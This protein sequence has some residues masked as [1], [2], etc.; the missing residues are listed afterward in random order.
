MMFHIHNV[1][2]EWTDFAISLSLERVIGEMGKDV[3]KLN[4]SDIKELKKV[5]SLSEYKLKKYL[6][7]HYYEKDVI[8]I[9]LES[10]KKEKPDKG[11]D[12][13]ILSEM[14]KPLVQME[15]LMPN[16]IKKYP[17]KKIIRS[18]IQKKAN[19][20]IETNKEFRLFS[21]ALTAVKKKEI[22]AEVLEK[23][24]EEF[25]TKPQVTPQDVYSSTSEVLYQV[26]GIIKHSD[27]LFKDI[28]N[29]NMRQISKVELSQL[30]KNLNKLIKIVQEKI[31]K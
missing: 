17:V 2:E 18:C 24:I 7:F 8:N 29:L 22:R 19:N 15:K 31:L 13:D 14:H 6:R 5:T 23:N 25:I 3:H 12:S 1:R 11:V 21:K 10:E 9:F 30:K 28:N 4:P 16:L 20:I 26:K 27:S